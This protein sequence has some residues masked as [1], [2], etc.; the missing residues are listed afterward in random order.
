MMKKSE[1]YS[2]AIRAI[3]ACLLWSTAFAGVKIGLNY[4]TPFFLAGIR[5]ILAGIMLIPFSGKIKNY[6][7]TVWI[8]RKLIIIVAFL[9][10]VVMYGLYYT[11][12]DLIPGSIAAI[13]IGASPLVTAL[14]THFSL[15]DD[16]FSRDKLVAILLGVTGIVFV[17]YGR[18][19]LDPMGEANLIGAVLLVLSMIVSAYANIVVSRNKNRINSVLL[20]SSQLLFGGIILTIISLFS[21]GRPVIEWSPEFLFALLWLSFLSAAAF[22][23]WFSLLKRPEVKVSELN[24]WKFLIP[25]FGAFFS[26]MMLPEESPTVISIIGVAV[27]TL[28]VILYYLPI[29]RK[30]NNN[31]I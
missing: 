17:V 22:S 18:Q 13:I 30:K 14:V 5:F 26:W 6:I 28:S 24:M 19:T 2:I 3:V 10:S 12:I 29:G 31:Q 23:I 9:Q 4:T 21:D 1:K 27:I 8:N 25:V 15:R 20:N 11:G 7:I 16:K